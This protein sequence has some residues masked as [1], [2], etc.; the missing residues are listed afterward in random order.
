MI[1]L[2][3]FIKNS[4]SEE[5]TLLGPLISL[6]A[7]C[8][9]LVVLTVFPLAIVISWKLKGPQPHNNK[10]IIGYELDRL[11][12][13]VCILFYL[14]D[15]ISQV[16]IVLVV[17]FMQSND[18]AQLYTCFFIYS[19]YWVLYFECMPFESDIDDNIAVFNQICVLSMIYMQFL[20]SGFVTS[21][22]F[23]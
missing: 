17:M 15:Y 20:C 8:V 3:Y 13:N 2:V 23:K 4:G 16:I 19:I 10:L 12:L 6:V 1:T 22:Y 9:I 5:G 11:G 14:L 21:E 18:L 7:A